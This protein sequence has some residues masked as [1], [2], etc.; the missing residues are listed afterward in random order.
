[1]AF[2]N[3]WRNTN[4]F[5]KEAEKFLKYRTYIDYPEGTYEFDQY[6]DEQEY[7]CTHGMTNSVGQRICGHHY[8]YLNFCQIYNKTEKRITFPDFWDT[9]A[10]VFEELEEAKK[11]GENICV[12]KA[13]QKG[14]SLKFI[15]LPLKEFYF[16][17][18]SISYI[19][20]YIEDKANRAWEMMEHMANHLDEHTDWRKTKKPFRKDFWK[21]QFSETISGR[22][23]LRGFKSEIHK[24]TLKQSPAQGVGGAIDSFIYDEAGLAPTLKKTFE[25]IDPATYD[26]SKKTGTIVFLGSV[27]ELNDCQGLKEIF[28]NPT[29][30]SFRAFENIWDDGKSGTNCGLFIPEHYSLK[31]FIDEW[32]NSQLEAAKEYCERKRIEAKKRN[33]ENY[34]LYISQRPFSPEEAFAQRTVSFFPI[35][36]IDNEITKLQQAS[37]FGM[38]V[39]LIEDEA[40]RI[41][42]TL[43]TRHVPIM[44]FPLKAD[45]NKEGAVVIY[46]PPKP[47]APWGT[48]FAGVDPVQNKKTTTS[49]SLAS[50]YIIKRKIA[51]EGTVEYERVVACYTGRYDDP[52]KTNEI[53]EK[54]IRYYNAQALVEIDVTSFVEHMIARK[55]QR[56]L[57]QKG[58]IA[59]IQEM[60]L[61]TSVHTPYGIAGTT[62]TQ[63]LIFEMMSDFLKEIQHKVF[64]KDTGEVTQIITGV[65]QIRDIMLLTELREW[66]PDLNVDRIMAFGYALFAATAHAQHIPMYEKDQL[67]FVNE[68]MDIIKNMHKSAFKNTNFLGKNNK[69]TTGAFR[70]PFK[71]I[72]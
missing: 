47:D 72:R 48:Y 3:E 34:R 65:Q 22:E 54:L 7:L 32:G 15:T 62:K 5:R 57:I 10:W 43:N 30:Y 14:G 69:T 40:G 36:A 56:H 49:D 13:R 70:Q 1:M 25:Y 50:C 9:D 28:Y 66:H 60:N 68:N 23:F 29:A 59:I 35:Q 61:N 27:G 44:E 33:P 63:D 8:F 38:T 58:N 26:G 31:G 17:R 51:K 16:H 39:E 19:A 64:D 55:M 24:L 52:V 42:H 53:M 21:A 20:A 67:D 41:K 18:E 37:E 46:D 12:V 11:A 45:T 2:F 71:N 4:E 6:W